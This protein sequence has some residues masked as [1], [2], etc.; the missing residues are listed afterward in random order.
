MSAIFDVATAQWRRMRAEYQDVLDAQ[1]AAAEHTCNGNLVNARGRAAGVT[2]MDVFTGPPN[3]VTAYA[4]D[5]L[6]EHLRNHPRLTLA[7][8]ERQWLDSEPAWDEA[9]A[10]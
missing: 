9:V 5:E 6:A 1:Y 3:V 2:G 7:E 4:S 10:S 8:F